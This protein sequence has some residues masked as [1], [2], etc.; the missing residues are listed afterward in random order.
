MEHINPLVSINLESQL[1]KEAAKPGTDGLAFHEI[2]ETL[3]TNAEN[4][5]ENNKA[6]HGAS[7]ILSTNTEKFVDYFL[8]SVQGKQQLDDCY[9]KHQSPA[10]S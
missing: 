4:I 5:K 3:Q 1:P 9:K 2:I 8:K 6:G 7:S 10:D